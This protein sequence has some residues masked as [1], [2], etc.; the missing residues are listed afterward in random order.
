[1]ARII[2]TSRFLKGASK[3]QIKNLVNYMATRP[4]VE[5]LKS[6]TSPA[7]ENQKKFIEEQLKTF[8]D[9]KESF[10]YEDYQKNPTVSNASELISSIAEKYNNDPAGLKN[11][12]DYIAKRPRAERSEQGHGL[13]SG[14]DETIS[15][16]KAAEEVANHEGIV[17]THVV[18]LRREDAERLGYDNADAWRKLVK[19]KIPVIAKSMN[20]PVDKLKW[21]GAFHNEGNHPHIHMIVYSA[22]KKKGYLNNKGIGTMRQ[23]FGTAI[24]HDDLLHVYEQKDEVR[25]ALK[26][27]TE[28]KIKEIAAKLRQEEKQSPVVASLLLELSKALK[29]TKGKKQYGWLDT[30]RKQMVNAIVSELVKDKDIFELY[31]RWCDYK[32]E[33]AKTYQSTPLPCGCL[34]DEPEFKNIKNLIIQYAVQIGEMEQL[35]EGYLREFS[36]PEE[37]LSEEIENA[38]MFETSRQEES[39]KQE[40]YRKLNRLLWSKSYQMACAY[41]KDGNIESAYPLL[42]KEAEKGNPYAL[43]DLGLLVLKGKTAEKDTAL[44]QGYF[45]KALTGFLREEHQKYSSTIQ[46]LIGKMYWNGYGIEPNPKKAAVWFSKAAEQE[47]AYAQ[48][49]LGKLY[50]DG[51][52]VKANVDEAA[53]WFLKAAEQ[54]NPY[55]QSALGSLYVFDKDLKNKELALYWLEKAAANGNEYAVKLIDFIQRPPLSM[56][57]VGATVKLFRDLSRM[58]ENDF[59]FQ[60]KHFE[61]IESKLLRKMAQKKAALGQKQTL[62]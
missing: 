12:I 39:N 21:Y 23:A 48:Y 49:V 46:Y 27:N 38:D 56:T 62:G 14:S 54:E 57:P 58:I 51:N 19:S 20:I 42:L 1:M 50:R 32:M 33:I 31:Q 28:K 55:A 60:Q 18:S 30:K 3:K 11:Y 37:S 59:L 5:K 25:K 52:G 24:F 53:K 6:N 16:S 17:W 36:N 43:Y 61:Q 41:L 2:F 40:R 9:I 10:E 44:A 45:K 35:Q 47:N 15:L 7:T 26:E 22:D 29:Q 34:E 4:G 8:P 13:W